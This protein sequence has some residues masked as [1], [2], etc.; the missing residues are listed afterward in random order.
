[1]IVHRSNRTEALFDALTALVTTPPDDP[2]AA[3][4]IVVQGAGMGRWLSLALARR[5]GI[6]ANP[7]F[8]FPRKLVDDAATAVL[9]PPPD[10]AA[11][12]GTEALLWAVAA[13]L[14]RQFPAAPFARLRAY[15]DDDR[16]DRKRLQLAARIA[17]LYDQY[18]LFRP[19]LLLAWEVGWENVEDTQ[20]EVDALYQRYFNAD[21]QAFIGARLTNDPDAEDRAVIGFNYRLPLLV[22]SS[23][24]LD[25]EGDARITLAKEF[26]LTSRLSAFGRVEYDTNTEWEWTAG[27][28][29]TLSRTTSIITQYHSEYGLGAGIQIR[30]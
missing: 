2:F 11:A 3:E 9:G 21:W 19:D 17:E 20:Y 4:T 26:Q 7:A 23:V 24:S 13:E 1:M 18:G 25:S 29:Y 28:D 10:S 12:Y 5:L 27:A 14:P 22:W 8:P 30:F 16:D 15:L 6:W